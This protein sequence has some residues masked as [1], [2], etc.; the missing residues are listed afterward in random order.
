MV[1]VGDLI[2]ARSLAL[3]CGER[4][5][6]SDPSAWNVDYY[7]RLGE[8]YSFLYGINDYS[9]TLCIIVAIVKFP[10]EAY[11]LSH[12]HVLLP[13]GRIARIFD[14][15]ANGFWLKLSS[16]DDAFLVSSCPGAFAWCQR[17]YNVQFR[18]SR[19]RCQ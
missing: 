5:E 7:N 2:R 10:D 3:V 17:H 12:F 15:M 1:K 9:L 18:R 16:F 6:L 11:N 19:S 8:D 14:D 4:Y 13:D